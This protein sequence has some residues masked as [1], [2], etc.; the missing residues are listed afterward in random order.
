MSWI[1]RSYRFICGIEGKTSYDNRTAH[2][3]IDGTLIW[4]FARQGGTNAEK[5]ALIEK[6]SERFR[7][8]NMGY[9][10]GEYWFDVLINV[11]GL[12]QADIDELDTFVENNK[13]V[14]G[15]YPPT[16]L[17]PAVTFSYSA[18]SSLRLKDMMSDLIG[19]G[20]DVQVGMFVGDD[21]LVFTDHVLSQAEKNR[22]SAMWENRLVFQ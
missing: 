20:M 1:P 6:W 17:N 7:S 4:Y 2:G 10:D 19:R 5:Q 3:S 13:S 21:F 15:R 9:V 14:W 8:L 18:I 22:M 11:D 16:L 12:V